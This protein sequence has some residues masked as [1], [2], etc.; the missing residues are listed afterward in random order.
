[1]VSPA[2]GIHRITRWKAEVCRTISADASSLAKIPLSPTCA[3][4]EAQAYTVIELSLASQSESWNS[5]RVGPFPVLDAGKASSSLFTARN[6]P[7]STD[8]LEYAPV[9]AILV[10]R[11]SLLGLEQQPR[12]LAPGSRSGHRT[13]SLHSH[14]A[15]DAHTHTDV[16]KG[17]KLE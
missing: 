8:F 11:L 15:R 5:R 4:F 17:A 14:R 1:M 2:V 3:S 12:E 6:E 13:L 9:I 16:M 10:H 7:M